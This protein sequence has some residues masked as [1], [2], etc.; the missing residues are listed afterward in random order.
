MGV[1][2]VRNKYHPHI[3]D[4]R[5]NHVRIL[6]LPRLHRSLSKM[7]ARQHAR[8][9]SKAISHMSGQIPLSTVA[10]AII[11]SALVTWIGLLFYEIASLAPEGHYTVRVRPESSNCAD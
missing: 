7:Y 2:N 9:S 4:V 10:E 11:E 3:I 5:Q 8:A 6:L 1:V